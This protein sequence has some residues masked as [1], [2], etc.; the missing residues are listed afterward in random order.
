MLFL[1]NQL[2]RLESQ[3]N[4]MIQIRTAMFSCFTQSS[5]L[6]KENNFFITKY[7]EHMLLIK[8]LKKN[9]VKFY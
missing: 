3:V 6:Q 9:V 4:K 1:E 5:Y 8:F 7:Q 2:L